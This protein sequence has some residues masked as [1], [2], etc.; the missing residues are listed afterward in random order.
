MNKEYAKQ[1][2]NQAT[3][4]FIGQQLVNANTVADT[5]RT[6]YTVVAANQK[7]TNAPNYAYGH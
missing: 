2:I 7:K 6:Y 4:T 3:P 5:F 1:I